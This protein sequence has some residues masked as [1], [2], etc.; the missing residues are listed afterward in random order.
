[1]KFLRAKECPIEHNL[2]YRPPTI[3]RNILR[4]G[5][6][7]ARSVV[8]QHRHRTQAPFGLVEHRGDLIGIANIDG[9]TY[10]FAAKFFYR[11]NSRGTMVRIAACDHNAR[12]HSSECAGHR[13]AESRPATSDYYHIILE[14][15]GGHERVIRC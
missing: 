7:P 6:E 11:R 10:C 9:E 14:R 2:G 1:M 3:W 5:H 8:D 15:I 4:W 12:T 13:L